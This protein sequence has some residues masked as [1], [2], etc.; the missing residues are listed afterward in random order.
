MALTAKQEDK[1]LHSSLFSGCDIKGFHGLT[2]IMMPFSLLKGENLQ[3]LQ[4]RETMGFLLSGKLEVSNLHGVLYYNICPGEFIGVEDLFSEIL[5]VVEY[6]IKA[7]T[8]SVL[9]FLK[10]QQ[11]RD[12]LEENTQI[13]ENYLTMLA[14]QVHHSVNRL[15][16]F[17]AP[18]PGIAL[19]MYLMQH[20]E[21]GMVRLIDGFAGLARRLNVSRATLYRS[22]AELEGLQ[23]ISHM[24]KTITILDAKRLHGYV[25]MQSDIAALL[26]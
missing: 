18:T 21:Q 8:N 15:Q 23:L 25:H 11:L 13:R 1:F 22:L 12:L 9:T 16:Q 14:D 20:E 19:G 7:K 4:E 3:E 26:D 24:E 5:P 10:K 2:Q 6:C 17:T